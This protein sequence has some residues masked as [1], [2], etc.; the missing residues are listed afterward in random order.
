MAWRFGAAVLLAAALLV[1]SARTD[2]LE[3]VFELAQDTLDLV[4]NSV[5]QPKLAAELK[6]LQRQYADAKERRRKIDERKLYAEVRELRRRIILSHPALDFDTLLINKRTASVPSHMC[7]QYL[8][9]HSRPG[10]GLTIL[11]NWKT[12]PEATGLLEDK[13]PPGMTYHPDL[14][15]DGQRVVFAFCVAG[16]GKLRAFYLY[17]AAI[18]GSWVTQ[19]TGTE[20][21]PREGALGR[22]TVVIEDYDPCYLPDGGIAFIST[23]S[24]QF[25]RCHGGRYV[26]SYC[27]YRCEGDGSSIRRISFNE[28][29]EWNPAVL[30]DGRIVYSRW[31]YINRHDTRFQSLWAMRPDGTGTVHY[32]GN[33]SS[34]PCMIAEPRQIPR[35][36]KIV[37]TGTDHHG[38]TAGTILVIDP[39]LGEDG[40]KPLFW[41]TPEFQSPEGSLPRETAKAGEPLRDDLAKARGPRGRGR[42]AT[43]YPLSE[44][45]FLVAYPHEEQFA[46]YLVDTLGGR[47]L[48]YYDPQWSCFN[49]IPVRPT[50]APPAL[51]PAVDHEEDQPT[52][53]FFV[54]P[55]WSRSR[56]GATHP[57]SAVR[58]KAKR[59]ESAT[60]TSTASARP[61]TVARRRAGQT[62]SPKHQQARRKTP[63]VK[64]TRGPRS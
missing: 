43:P 2:E 45:L 9:C 34:A 48:I 54:R 7:D 57:I 18:D 3:R 51:A 12:S 53:R 22:K 33:Y 8:G 6:A 27:L 13:L 40:P 59:S 26:P 11:E 47:E 23:R 50:V 30:A 62:A 32:Y 42:A 31:D 14:S 1:S 39:R 52:G 35:S 49:P 19:L 58:M 60:R 25:G 64:L 16:G 17:E 21:D 28:A 56:F 46:I 44:D 24:Q 15:Y 63:L 55:T 36:H 41:I 4:E 38:Y 10:P 5:R 37:A 29:N 20:D 61:S